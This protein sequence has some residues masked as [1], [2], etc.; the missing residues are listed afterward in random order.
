MAFFRNCG[1]TSFLPLVAML[2]L[3]NDTHVLA[4]VCGSGDA[5]MELGVNVVCVT[6]AS[7]VWVM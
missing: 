4:V 3:S 5:M 7:L 6:H 1:G 2:Y